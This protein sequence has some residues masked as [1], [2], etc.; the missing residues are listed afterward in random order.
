MPIELA[1][2]CYN[3]NNYNNNKQSVYQRIPRVSNPSLTPQSQAED[4]DGPRKR[5]KYTRSTKGCLPC[6]SHKVKCDET[7]P[8]CL[9]CVASQRQC[10]YPPPRASS[11]KKR[12]SG[13]SKSVTQVNGDGELGF[14]AEA[15]PSQGTTGPPTSMSTPTVDLTKLHAVSSGS[16][17]PGGPITNPIL[18]SFGNGKEE[19][20]S[21]KQFSPSEIFNLTPNNGPGSSISPNDQV[22]AHT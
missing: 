12:G 13:R 8:T 2:S 15:G 17:I 11:D 20:V 19:K 4:P 3:S 22:S 7:T 10:E 5:V 9:R 1:Q 21:P 14:N 6:R 18:V 16:A